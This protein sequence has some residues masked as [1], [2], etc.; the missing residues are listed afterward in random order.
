MKKIEA[1]IRKSKFRYVKRSLLDE[2]FKDFEYHLTRSS[3]Q[4][5]HRYYRGVEYD[6]QAEE[7]IKVSIYLK[8]KEVEKVLDIIKN[9]GET[10]D[11][12]EG[13]IGIYKPEKMYRL[14]DDNGIDKLIEII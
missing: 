9:S 13:F 6:A 14:T 12:K 1:I 4:S 5:E 10:G 2:G 8:D 7:R 11:A 3:A